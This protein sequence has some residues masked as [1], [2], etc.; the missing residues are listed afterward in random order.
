MAT[1]RSA[2]DWPSKI[3]PAARAS[4]SGRRTGGQDLRPPLRATSVRG[5]RAEEARD[6]AREQREETARRTGHATRD[7]IGRFGACES[8][9]IIGSAGRAGGPS[10]PSCSAGGSP[11]SGQRTHPVRRAACMCVR[12]LPHQRVGRGQRAGWGE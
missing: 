2:A 10:G 1:L 12:P 3:P 11:R 7:R 9:G 6:R 5:S 8:L 4:G